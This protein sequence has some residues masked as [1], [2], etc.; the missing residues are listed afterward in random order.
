[1]V[2]CIPE[3]SGEMLRILDVLG[4]ASLAYTAAKDKK[5]GAS[6]SRWKA[7][8]DAQACPLTYTHT[9]TKQDKHRDTYTNKHTDAHTDTDTHTQ[10]IFI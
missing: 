5:R 10:I 4:T 9:H 2:L 1:M 3:L 8:S 6:Q 7:R